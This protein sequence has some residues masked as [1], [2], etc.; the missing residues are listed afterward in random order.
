MPIMRRAALA[1]RASAFALEFA[2]CEPVRVTEAEILSPA[3][4]GRKVEYW[5]AA[6]ETAWVVRE[7]TTAYHEAPAARLAALVRQICLARG[8]DARC[9]GATD[10]RFQREDG[11]LGDIMQ[12]DQTVYLHPHPAALP[13]GG[14]VI[15]GDDPLPD[16]VLEVD[17]TTDVRRGKLLAYA[18]WGLPEVWVEVPE[19]GA[20]RRPRSRR[21]GLVIHLLEDDEYRPSPAS[22][23][24]PGW[25]AD[26]I[27]RALNE[28]VM[29]EATAEALWRVGRALGEREGTAWRD[30]PLLARVE[31][32][33]HAQG[34]TEGHARALTQAHAAMAEALLRRRGIEVPTDFA[35]SL[36]PA[37]RGRLATASPAALVEAAATADSA[38]DF[39]ARL[40]R[41][42]PPRERN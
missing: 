8:S 32:M 16:V 24:F 2:G 40:R 5:H 14:R 20:A 42:T 11:T 22:R 33:S 21:P 25:R 4:E 19:A 29:S 13:T 28:D 34:V 3:W 36:S 26:E 38:N 18:G 12:A 30:D 31:R 37:H 7:P 39:L 9:I 27:H 1:D 23:A 41:S 35:A 10:L 17:H 15:V 6:A